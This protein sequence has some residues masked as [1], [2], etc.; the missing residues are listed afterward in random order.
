MTHGK[1]KE[2]A[3]LDT[4][5]T[6]LMYQSATPDGAGA[7]ASCSRSL[8]DTADLALAAWGGA[9]PLS[10]KSL[11]QAAN[12]APSAPHMLSFASREAA[13]ASTPHG[14]A[15]V[16]KPVDRGPAATGLDLGPMDTQALSQ[17]HECRLSEATQRGAAT[18]T[19]GEI[20][21]GFIAQVRLLQS[22]GELSQQ[23]LLNYSSCI[24]NNFRTLLDRPVAALR[25]KE[26][27]QWML[28]L[29]LDV[30][31]R[32]R[33]KKGA[34]SANQ[35]LQL[36]KQA[37]EFGIEEELLPESARLLTLKVKR[38]KQEPRTRYFSVEEIIRLRAALM[39][40]EQLRVREAQRKDRSRRRRST[41]DYLP[42]ARNATQALLLI[43]LTAMRLNEALELR[44]E[45][46]V[47]SEG[48][49]RLP[50]SKC[51]FREVP[52]SSAA[53]EL[54]RQQMKRAKDGWMFP[55][56]GGGHITFVYHVWLAALQNA[57]ID[58]ADAVVHTLRHSLI[59]DVLRN[60]ADLKA[61]ADIAGHSDLDVTRSI[62]GRPLAT[63]DARQAVEDFAAR[64]GAQRG[65]YRHLKA[66]A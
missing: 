1:E 4:R 18:I 25:F 56:R 42:F 47:L 14:A 21:G 31:D 63:L 36:L 7:R 40:V 55:A 30:K 29:A 59:T 65:I 28:Q 22:V 45:Q 16:D 35:A 51:G 43:S 20:L 38:L 52:L 61:A 12:N 64:I 48:L 10:F 62:Y 53:I 27:R 54:L 66:A 11:S 8:H 3:S 50:D 13:N 58:S 57:E 5:L 46:V 37:I 2:Q 24:K 33:G 23:T 9:T 34:A 32:P 44:V 49:L 26:I 19:V 6:E 39:R 41:V 17:F 15:P 60:G